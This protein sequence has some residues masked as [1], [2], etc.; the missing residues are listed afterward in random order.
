[1][2]TTKELI[3]RAE[4]HGEGWKV[5]LDMDRESLLNEQRM[6]WDI[7]AA[8]RRLAVLEEFKATWD[9]EI[10][11]A[12]VWRTDCSCRR[13]F[14]VMSAAASAATDAERRADA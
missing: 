7:L 5:T 8:A 11:K 10:G 2:T 4:Q 6:A 1:V 3:K 9:R 13:L 12:G 14:S